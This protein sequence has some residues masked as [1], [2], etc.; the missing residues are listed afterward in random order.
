MS[1]TINYCKDNGFVSTLFGRKIFIPF[2]NDKNT[3]RRNFGE[4]SAI[5]APIQGGAADMIKRSM[6]QI[7]RYIS[8]NNL[9][10]KMLL[11]VHDELI[12]EIPKS[13]I[14]S[15]PRKIASIMEVSFKPVLNFS[16]PL[17]AEIGNGLNW[18]EAH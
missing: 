12:F 10:T 6:I 14:E 13:E 7:D 9:E 3:A 16:V 4:R 1:S 15:V 2:I 18:A 17:R 11:Q 8:S 5:N